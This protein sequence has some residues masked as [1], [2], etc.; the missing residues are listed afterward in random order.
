MENAA[1]VNSDA[2]E[3]RLRLK[4]VFLRSLI[5]SLAACALIAVG[6][7]LFGTF[8]RTTGRIL[9]TLGILAVHSGAALA[10]AD[11]LERR[12]WPALSRVG[13]VLFTLNFAWFE[14][15]IW[16]R[17]G[18][19]VE[20]LLTTLTLIGYY[21]GAIPTVALLDKRRWRVVAWLS[22]VACVASFFMCLG[23]VWFARELGNDFE[24][25]TIAAVII[26]G[27]FAHTCLL[28]FVRTTPLSLWVLRGTLASM[29]TFAILSVWA[30]LK[31]LQPDL[32]IRLI[33]AA[34]VLDICGN[35]VLVILSRLN[36]VRQVE[37]LESTEKQIELI[38]PRCAKQQLLTSGA[39]ECSDCGLRFRI[40]IEEPRCPGC[41]YLLWQLPERRCPECGREF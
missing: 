37:G 6:V 21:V 34:G 18:P 2:V 16:F 32:H 4:R 1:P 25:W 15:L 29:W 35:L 39:A 5:I 3:S 33:G 7:L 10:C 31:Q 13:L 40:E 27:S 38:C 19:I 17:D 30:V 8:N 36:K 22:L 28:G 26:A 24:R 41:G 20:E 11:S 12:W 9:G 14:T 23:M